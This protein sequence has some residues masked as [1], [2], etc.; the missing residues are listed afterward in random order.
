MEER[1]PATSPALQQTPWARQS[2]KFGV[3][4]MRPINDVIRQVGPATKSAL[5]IHGAEAGNPPPGP[6][7]VSPRDADESALPAAGAEGTFSALPPPGTMGEERKDTVGEERRGAGAPE[8]RAWWENKLDDIRSTAQGWD[9]RTLPGSYLEPVGMAMEA[10]GSAVTAVRSATKEGYASLLTN[11]S[12]KPEQDTCDRFEAG[13]VALLRSARYSPLSAR[14]LDVQDAL[15]QDYLLTLPVVVE[16]GGSSRVL[17]FRRELKSSRQTGL[18]L[19]PKLDHLQTVL[20]GAILGAVTAPTIWLGRRVIQAWQDARASGELSPA[21][22]DKVERWLISRVVNPLRR[23]PPASE[24][25]N[26]PMSGDIKTVG[27]REAARGG[28]AAPGEEEPLQDLTVLASRTAQASILRGLL[29]R[30]GVLSAAEAGELAFIA[31]EYIDPN[32]RHS[33]LYIPRVA[34]RDVFTPIFARDGTLSLGARMRDLL[35]VLARPLDLREPAFGTVVLMYRSQA[36]ARGSG[37]SGRPFGNAA[38]ELL[39]ARRH[40]RRHATDARLVG[41]GGSPAT[42]E[43]GGDVVA[44]ASDGAA[45]QVPGE[46]GGDVTDARGTARKDWRAPWME[47]RPPPSSVVTL[48][49]FQDIPLPDL[50]IVFPNKRLG[51]RLFDVHRSRQFHLCHLPAGHKEARPLFRDITLRR[52]ARLFPPA[53]A[54]HLLQLQTR[55]RPVPAVHHEDALRE[56]GRHRVCGGASAGLCGGGAAA[57]GGIA[58]VRPS[59]G[60]GVA[61][62]TGGA[63]MGDGELLVERFQPQGGDFS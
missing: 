34:V 54:T 6:A 40:A 3:G 35:R 47:A 9:G 48:K 55:A 59:V 21:I 18:L 2:G 31:E 5:R 29:V 27:I 60:L 14:D 16:E 24:I 36:D 52:R 28:E 12:K 30:L 22:A 57:Q 33:P 4:A 58:R 19:G 49:I 53:G 15:K 1:D 63:R 7:A 37:P 38:F 62:D 11:G 23:M 17:V 56:D 26:T 45:G 46:C 43:E 41:E 51:F 39:G 61:H 20:V 10:L 42:E 50:K 32:M 44:D 8:R 25:S 13:I